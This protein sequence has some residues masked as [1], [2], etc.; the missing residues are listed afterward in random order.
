ML[1]QDAVLRQH[2]LAGR[3]LRI[4]LQ[5]TRRRGP[6]PARD[7]ARR[8]PEGHDRDRGNDDSRI[9]RREGPDGLR[10]RGHAE[11]RTEWVRGELRHPSAAA[12]LFWSAGQL[13]VGGAPDRRAGG[14]E[15]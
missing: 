14:A 7:N 13:I 9:R 5:E 8:D 4:G 15:V 1:W 12:K 10:E 6:R 2:A 3:L 11:V